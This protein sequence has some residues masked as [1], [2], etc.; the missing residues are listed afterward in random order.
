MSLSLI[1][2]HMIRVISSPSS[3]TTGFATLIFAMWLKFNYMM[4]I[5]LRFYRPKNRSF[6]EN[7][8]AFS[9]TYQNAIMDN[10][11]SSLRRFEHVEAAMTLI[12]LIILEKEF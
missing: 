9:F 11:P 7:V 12:I 3:S 4:F 5:C 6:G 8:A 10:P 1:Y 2:F